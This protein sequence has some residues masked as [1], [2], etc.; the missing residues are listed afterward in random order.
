MRSFDDPNNRAASGTDTYPPPQSPQHSP[1]PMP[2]EVPYVPEPGSA[3]HQQLPVYQFNRDR[4]PAYDVHARRIGLEHVR[5]ESSAPQPGQYYRART[6]NYPGPNVSAA[7]YPHVMNIDL[8]V[9]TP[10]PPETGGSSRSRM[11]RVPASSP[12]RN[13]SARDPGPDR[14]HSVDDDFDIPRRGSPSPMSGHYS[15]RAVNAEEDLVHERAGTDTD[16]PA[17]AEVDGPPINSTPYLRTMLGLGPEDEV[18][19]NALADPPEGEKPNYPYPTL[20]KLA[21]HGSRN[22]RLTLQDI[23]QALEDRFEWYRAN[24]EDKSWQVC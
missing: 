5:N 12:H 10:V 15:S 8:N 23:Y 2:A 18:S 24:A 17:E 13:S 3:M 11:R 20:I 22:K 9:T 19:L 16:H 4:Y 6:H 21:I 1:R 14:E 7:D